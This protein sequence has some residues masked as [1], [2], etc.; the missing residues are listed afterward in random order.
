[1]GA[2]WLTSMRGEK[3]MARAEVGVLT[4]TAPPGT[5][6]AIDG[7]ER[8]AVAGREIFLEPKREHRIEARHGSSIQLHTITLGRGTTRSLVILFTSPPLGDW[9]VFGGVITG[10][11]L[12]LGSGALF[13]ASA[14]LFSDAESHRKEAVKGFAGCTD[15]SRSPEHCSAYQTSFNNAGT[16]RDSAYVALAAA[17]GIGAT[18]IIY[19]LGKPAA[20]A[21]RVTVGLASVGL[22]GTW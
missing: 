6:V 16:L 13:A 9:V 5:E 15:V 18:T 4:I 3:A 11:A 8:G 21:P 7:E 12:A 19:H 1:M 22:A 17:G 20:G 10:T 2:E 14:V